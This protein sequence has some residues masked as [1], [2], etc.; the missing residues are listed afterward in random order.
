MSQTS[1][2]RVR[3]RAADERSVAPVDVQGKSALFSGA[4]VTPSL[5]S[6]AITCSACHNATVLPYAQVL[7]YALPSVHLPVI[8]RPYPSWMR[9]PACAQRH[10][11]RIAFR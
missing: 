8:R 9:C 6:V 1:F 3:T 10:W 11:V 5:G 2:D 4:A 7:R